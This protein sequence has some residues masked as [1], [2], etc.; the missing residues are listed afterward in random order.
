MP[1]A[2]VTVIVNKGSGSSTDE[3]RAAIETALARANLHAQIVAVAGP[4]IQGAAE[5]AAARGRHARSRPVAT[6]RSRPSPRSR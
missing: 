1:T 3:S 6:A 2:A 4:E 5:K